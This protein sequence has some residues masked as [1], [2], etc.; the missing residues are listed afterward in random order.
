MQLRLVTGSQHPGV[1]APTL[2]KGWKDA[3]ENLQGF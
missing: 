2:S 3:A 1:A